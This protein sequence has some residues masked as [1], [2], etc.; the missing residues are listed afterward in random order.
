MFLGIEDWGLKTIP[1]PQ[2]PIP[3]TI[4]DN[5]SINISY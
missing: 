5:I 3:K 2:S 1:N 4:K